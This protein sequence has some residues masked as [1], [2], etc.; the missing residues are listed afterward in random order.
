MIRGIEKLT[1]MFGNEGWTVNEINGSLELLNNFKTRKLVYR[2]WPE[3]ISGTVYYAKLELCFKNEVGGWEEVFR[4]RHV[5][6]DSKEELYFV[7][8]AGSSKPFLWTRDVGYDARRGGRVMHGLS[9]V[10]LPDDQGFYRVVEDR[11]ELVYAVDDLPRDLDYEMT[12]NLFLGQVLRGEMER[13]VMVPR[14]LFE[15]IEPVE[16]APGSTAHAPNITT[17]AKLYLWAVTPEQKRIAGAINRWVVE[18]ETR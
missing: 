6:M 1:D 10:E 17:A 12:A 13:P 7:V 14:G 8:E 5:M 11:S 18:Q 15:Y 3:E 4:M 9:K 16:I 2:T